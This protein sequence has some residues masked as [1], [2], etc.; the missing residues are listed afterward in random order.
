MP[1]I[2]QENNNIVYLQSAYIDIL[3]EEINSNVVRVV[4]EIHIGNKRAWEKTWRISVLY[5]IKNDIKIDDV[6]WQKNG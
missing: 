1:K 2:V 6:N 5:K 3:W 4:M